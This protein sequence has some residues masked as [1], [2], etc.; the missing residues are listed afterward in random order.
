[1]RAMSR[2]IKAIDP[3]NDPLV[4]QTLGDRYAIKKIIGRGGVG[5]VYLA[6]DELEPRDV[7]VKVL[8]PQW[9]EDD[10]ALARF[11]REAKRLENL[12]HPNIVAMYDFGQEDRTAYLV[13]EYLQGELLS[14]YVDRNAALTLAQFVPIAAQILKGIGHAHSREM[15]VRDIKPA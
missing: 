2:S 5:L 7:V 12:R 13:M 1:T 6:R 10:E 3:T 8:A 4:G 15:M 9:A 14:A 11:E